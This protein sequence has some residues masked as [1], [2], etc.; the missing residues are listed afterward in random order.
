MGWNEDPYLAVFEAS[1]PYPLAPTW[2]RPCGR[3]RVARMS[4]V[5]LVDSQPAQA[6]ELSVFTEI[7]PVFVLDLDAVVVAVGDDQP[8]LG[9]EHDRVRCPARHLRTNSGR[10]RK[11][12][13]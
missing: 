8:A 6:A 1:D 4:R 10:R 7:L 3:F 5:G 11:E 2:V 12:N 9:I 13:R